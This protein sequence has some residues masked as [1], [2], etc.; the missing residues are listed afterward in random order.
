MAAAA[1]RCACAPSQVV[2][3]DRPGRQGVDA[4][5]AIGIVQRGGL[6]QADDTV[7]GRYI[8]GQAADRFQTGG[9][10]QVDD[11]AAAALEH[12]GDLIL[13]RQEL[14]A[15]A[16]V[17][18]WLAAHPPVSAAAGS[19]AAGA[20]GKPSGGETAMPAGMWPVRL[21]VVASLTPR[22]GSAPEGAGGVAIDLGE[23]VVQAR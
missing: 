14:E 6:D 22:R 11:G 5:V 13:H 15:V 12:G 20:I 18:A 19:A 23:E 21:T 8:P 16:A 3:E 17:L 2:G 10:R 9:G 1:A 4:Q 7:L